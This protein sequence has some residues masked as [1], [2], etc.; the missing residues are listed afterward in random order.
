MQKASYEHN[1][2]ALYDYQ[3]RDIH[4]VLRGKELEHAQVHNSMTEVIDLIGPDR[5]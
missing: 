4:S 1:P 5:D 3:A 2:T